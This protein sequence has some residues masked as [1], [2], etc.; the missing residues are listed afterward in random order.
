MQKQKISMLLAAYTP[1]S[2]AFLNKKTTRPCPH[3]P[4]LPSVVLLLSR[5]LDDFLADAA[6]GTPPPLLPPS[7]G[8]TP[9]V[10]AA[11]DRRACSDVDER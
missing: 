7:T 10:A 4:S 8:P 9:K 11:D 1:N 2:S 6:A 3:L 5:E